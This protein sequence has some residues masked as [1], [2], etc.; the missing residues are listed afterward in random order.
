MHDLHIAWKVANAASADS[1][2]H[3]WSTYHF[4]VAPSRQAEFINLCRQESPFTHRVATS[5]LAAA[6]AFER[7]TGKHES[8][9][10]LLSAPAKAA[11]ERAEYAKAFEE[12]LSAIAGA[13]IQLA[14]LAPSDTNRAVIG[15]PAIGAHRG[16]A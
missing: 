8:V 11:H 15:H 4:L 12:A 5:V 3:F 9:R 13:L 1:A 6:D 7:L 16:N 14:K 2:R 10:Q